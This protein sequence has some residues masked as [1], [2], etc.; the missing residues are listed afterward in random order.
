MRRAVLFGTGFGIGYVLGAHAGRERYE[1]IASMASQGWKSAGW[2]R[3]AKR[4]GE[5]VSETARLAA[6]GA[7]DWVANGAVAV[8]DVAKDKAESFAASAPGSDGTQAEP[9]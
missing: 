8:V 7:G 9:T 4:V 5:H 2:D 1:Q 3:S 6:Q